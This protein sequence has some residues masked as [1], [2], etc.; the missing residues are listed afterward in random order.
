MIVGSV[1][2]LNVTCYAMLCGYPWGGLLF[3]EGKQEEWIWV[4]GKMG[5]ERLRGDGDWSGCNVFKKNKCI[6]K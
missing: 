5:V 2:N 4:R 1:P 3:S 6:K